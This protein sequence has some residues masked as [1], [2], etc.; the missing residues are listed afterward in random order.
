M[1]AQ[2]RVLSVAICL[3]G[4]IGFCRFVSAGIIESQEPC[5]GPDGYCL[6]FSAG[7]TIP[8]IRTLD[9]NAPSPGT[10]AVSFHGSAYCLKT[11][12]LED[13]IVDLVTQIVGSPT[14]T[15]V[16]TGPGAL[17]MAVVLKD[18]SNHTL[19]TSDTLNL[20][21]TRVFAFATAGIQQFSF[22]IEPLKMDASTSCFVYNAAF[23]VHFEP[24]P[25]PVGPTPAVAS[26]GD[27]STSHPFFPFVEAL[28]T[29]GITGGCQLSPPL[30]CPDAP[31]TLGQMAVFLSK[32]LGLLFAP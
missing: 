19:N 20:A 23:T 8:V 30:F 18:A 15:P 10:A 22:K 7:E 24:P 29:S 11:G 4:L 16:P 27:V 21:S 3:I 31:L 17:R 12:S 28:K 5:A 9:F 25:L 6:E 2:G 32:G 13:K 26:F 14:E 1:T